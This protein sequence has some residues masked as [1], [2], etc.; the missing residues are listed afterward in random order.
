MYNLLLGPPGGGKS[1]EAVVYHVLPTLESG[2][3]VITNLPLNV[4]EFAKLDARFPGLIELRTKTRAQEPV[5]PSIEARLP[6]GRNEDRYSRHV[7]GN[8]EDYGDDWRD[9]VTGQG[10]F[11]VID[12]AHEPLRRGLTNRSVEEW[13]AK[14]RHEGADLLLLTQSYG[15]L[16][17]AIA[18]SAQVVYRVKKRTAFGDSKS[19]I[20]KVQDGVRG[21]VMSTVERT[22]DQKF[23]RLYKSHTRSVS[24]VLEADAKDISPAFIKWKRAGYVAMFVGVL[25]LGTNLLGHFRHMSEKPRVREHGTRS[26]ASMPR[27]AHPAAGSA[28]SAAQPVVQGPVPVSAAKVAPFDGLGL[29]ILGNITK[30]GERL[31]VFALTQNGQMVQRLSRAD[32]EESG[33]LVDQISDCAAKLTY[34]DR[35]FFVRCDF[36]TVGVSG[37]GS[38]DTAGTSASV[39]VDQHADQG[40]HQQQGV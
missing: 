20:R 6:F 28:A 29:H 13:F 5:S 19:Y 26:V 35:S 36:A 8:I 24:A 25:W 37:K 11:Y 32:I 39:Q 12:E 3:K 34:G 18:D 22:Y 40:N 1:Y 27:A 7:F 38:D 30:S 14:H 16:S 23:F 17:K 15:K 9:P 33:Y 10:A 21:E 31:Y 4:A 2:R